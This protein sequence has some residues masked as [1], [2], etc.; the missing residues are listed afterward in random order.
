MGSQKQADWLE[1]PNQCTRVQVKDLASAHEV[2]KR[3]EEDT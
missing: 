3:S 1:Y 2:K